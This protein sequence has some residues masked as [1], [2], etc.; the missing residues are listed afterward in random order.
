MV[1]FV[2]MILCQGLSIV[3]VSSEVRMLV[4]VVMMNMLFQV[5]DDCCMQLVIGISSVVVFLVVQSRLVLVVVNLVLNV[6]VQVEGKSEQILFQVKNMKFESSMNQMGLCFQRY[7]I[8]ILNFFMLKVMNMVFLWLIMLEIQLKNGWV[9][10]FSMWL[11]VVVKV[12][13]VI[14]IVISVMGMLLIFQLVVIGLRLVVIINLLVLMIM[15]MKY[16]SQKIGWCSI[17]VG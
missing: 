7:S 17:L 16:I 2:I 11:I 15:N 8:Q 13:V 4:F 12:I 3:I 6:L 5:F 14:V 1:D 10:L 9:R